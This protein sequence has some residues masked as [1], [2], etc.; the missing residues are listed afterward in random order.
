MFC[1]GDGS[2]PLPN[3]SE[4]LEATAG[5]ELVFLFAGPGMPRSCRGWQV[6]GNAPI[7]AGATHIDAKPEVRSGQE[8]GVVVEPKSSQARP[9]DD[10]ETVRTGPKDE[11]RFLVEAALP[12]GEYAVRLVARTPGLEAFYDF[13]VRLADTAEGVNCRPLALQYSAGLR[14]ASRPTSTP[15]V[16]QLPEGDPGTE[17]GP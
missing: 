2:V 5:S 16:S 9:M 3:E 12:P 11:G 10:L 13:R 4:T 8:G 7:H 6:P 17:S 1:R 15:R 14:E